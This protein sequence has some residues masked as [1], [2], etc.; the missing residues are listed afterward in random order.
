MLCDKVQKGKITY[1]RWTKHTA[2]N[3]GQN[4]A[5]T[6][7]AECM[8]R[9][10]LGHIHTQPNGGHAEHDDDNDVTLPLSAPKL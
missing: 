5:F 2:A 8:K 1:R 4:S 7:G 10:L 3:M 6:A 9:P